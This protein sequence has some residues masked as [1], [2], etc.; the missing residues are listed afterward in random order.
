MRGASRRRGACDRVPHYL[1]T[2]SFAGEPSIACLR[3]TGV[4]DALMSKTRISIVAGAM[5]L[6]SLGAGAAF[7]DDAVPPTPAPVT[8]A[9]PSEVDPE[10][11][12]TYQWE[13][14]QDKL[15]LFAEWIDKR[16]DSDAD[17]YVESVNDAEHLATTVLWRGR[18]TPAQEAVLA[19]GRRR[20]ITV[21]IEK[22]KYDYAQ[23]EKAADQVFADVEA[24]KWQGYDV[25]AV[26]G[27]RADYDGITVQA[28][29]TTR[30]LPQGDQTAATQGPRAATLPYADGVVAG[31][32]VRLDISADPVVPAA[33]VRWD[34]TA[35]FNAGGMM[36]GDGGTGGCSSGFSVNYEGRTHTV[37]ARHCTD[38]PYRS[39]SGAA[40]YGSGEGL[41]SDGAAKVLGARGSSWMFDGSYNNTNGLKKTVVS[42]RD[43][44]LGDKV[45]TS[46]G[47]SGKHCGLTVTDMSAF[48][49]DKTGHG[50]VSTIVA[51]APTAADLAAARGDSGGPV[52]VIGNDPYEVRA[53]GMI[54]AIANEYVS[55]PTR[56]GNNICGNVVFFTSTKTIVHGLSGSSLVTG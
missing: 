32:Q 22:R 53:V 1:I 4:G 39:W 20:G 5:A 8:P 18:A 41:S 13:R 6:M 52:Y 49:D 42:L 14:N 16:D 38:V 12:L 7:A 35:P 19:E 3:L 43:V 36:R 28:T 51:M 48:W 40:N 24:G 55:C 15:Q 45:C 25:S 54:Q 9:S 37:T 11:G 10:T 50:D 56:A 23:I 47:N 27:M 29:P 46:G 30:A 33:A 31:V 44:G 34:D 2:G 21:T 17:G 26:S